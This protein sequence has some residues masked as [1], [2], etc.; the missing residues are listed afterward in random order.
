MSKPLHGSLAEAYLRG[1]AITHLIDLPALRFH[2]RCYY[3]L[4]ADADTQAWPALIAAVTDLHGAITGVQKIIAT[5]LPSAVSPYYAALNPNPV[6]AF[7]SLHAAFPFL[8]FLAVREVFSR[9]AAWA[10]L[11]WCVAV[12]F[13]VVYLGEHYVVDVI[14]G[15]ALA[16]LVWW[17]LNHAVAPRYW[18][19]RAAQ[20]LAPPS[21][22]RLPVAV[23]PTA[24]PEP[25]PAPE[26]E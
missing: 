4:D 23:A 18:P 19:L 5:T 10:V 21:P 7:P 17:V 24:L 11:A 16:A 8:G 12:W 6:A 14:A 1:R 13:S 9:R 20:T 26:P 2:P 15:V 25:L 3:R 22:A